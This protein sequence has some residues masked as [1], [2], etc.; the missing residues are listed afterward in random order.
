MIE[1]FESNNFM[2]LYEKE[3]NMHDKYNNTFLMYL[4]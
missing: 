3:I 4:C 1:H 2:M